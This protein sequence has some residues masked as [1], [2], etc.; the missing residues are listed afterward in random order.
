MTGI[1]GLL[2][3]IYSRNSRGFDKTPLTQLSCLLNEGEPREEFK[4]IIS[5]WVLRTGALG[6]ASAATRGNIAARVG[7]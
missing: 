3:S 4:E 6:G 7:A 5:K 2:V 1:L